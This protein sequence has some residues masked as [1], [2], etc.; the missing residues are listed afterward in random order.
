MDLFGGEKYMALR[1]I[2]RD[3]E[4]RSQQLYRLDGEMQRTR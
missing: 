3:T 1:Q 4:G 2:L